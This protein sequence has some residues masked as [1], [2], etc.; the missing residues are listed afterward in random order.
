MLRTTGRRPGCLNPAGKNFI[1]A[2]ILGSSIAL[3][4]GCG[5]LSAPV[6]LSGDNSSPFLQSTDLILYDWED[7]TPRAVLDAFAGEFGVNVTVVSYVSQEEAIDRLKAGGTYD[8]VVMESRHIPKLLRE[9]L[10]ADIDYRNVPNASYLSANFRDLVYDPGNRH[11]LPY[12]WGVTGLAVRSDL[13]QGRV[14]RW[15]DLWQPHFAGRIGIWY[16]VPRDVIALTLKSLG[17]SANSER[18]DELEAAYRRLLQLRTQAIALESIDTGTAAEAL[19]SGRVVIAMAYALDVQAAREQ[20]AHVD[21]IFPE[22][23]ALLWNDAWVIPK[24][25]PNRRLAESFL[26]YIL[27][28]EVGAQMIAGTGYAAPNDAAVALLSP[29]LLN[30]PV[31]FPPRDVLRGAEIILPLSP[32][33]ERRYREIWERLSAGPG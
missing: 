5:A 10:L 21:F 18:P 28:P 9:N 25:S 16:S 27:R 7:G 20:C 13:V 2:V 30:D 23:G 12:N 14:N 6:R 32:E 17:C 33:G 3:S 19:C 26:N 4:C 8:L 24:T 31:I 22:E 15:A 29:E 1:A 11:S